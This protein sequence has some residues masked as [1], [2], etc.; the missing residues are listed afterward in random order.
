M[1]DGEV[2]QSG[3]LP[4]SCPPMRIEIGLVNNMPD[5]ALAA[6]ERQFA[7]LIA[8][9]GGGLD[10][11]L[12]LYSLPGVP[13][14]DAARL[15]M[16]DRYVE[17]DDPTALK[18]DALIVTGNEP[19]TAD[20]RSEPYFPHLARLIDW[21]EHST[22]ST[23][24]SCLAAHAAVLHLDGVERRPLP[25]KCAGVFLCEQ[26]ADDPL[27]AGMAS[28]IRMPHSRRNGLSVGDLA[29]KGY[30]LLTHSREAGADLFVRR[31]ESLFVFF[32]GHPEY[33]ADG[34][35]KEYCRDVG[36]HLRGEMD[37]PPPLPVG[38]FDARTEAA[39]RALAEEARRARSPA[40]IER[41]AEIAAEFHPPHPW[42]HHAEVLF[43]NW[44]QQIALMKAVR[45]LPAYAFAGAREGVR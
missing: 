27:M 18:V 44:L 1:A 43:A 42:R 36:R 17:I 32:Q 12:K 41:C 9:A 7:E 6:T 13:R 35:L 20:I 8:A 10:V 38:Y 5:A 33:D 22:L 2:P 29:A 30:H 19:K 11:R 45:A 23:L 25:Q 37:D 31:G 14:S 24:W 40:L 16:R 34:L 4:A 15:A 26:V 21:A 28:M 3:D 39:F